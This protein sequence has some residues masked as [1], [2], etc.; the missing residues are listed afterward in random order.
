MHHRHIFPGL[1]TTCCFQRG[2]RAERRTAKTEE[3][4]PGS[5]KWIFVHVF[6]TLILKVLIRVRTRTSLMSATSSFIFSC[7]MATKCQPGDGCSS[8]MSGMNSRSQE[9]SISLFSSQLR[10][11]CWKSSVWRILPDSIPA[12]VCP[13]WTELE[14]TSVLSSV[15][16]LDV[17]CTLLSVSLGIPIC[18]LFTLVLLDTWAHRTRIT[19]N[20][21]LARIR[22]RKRERRL[23]G[24]NPPV[25]SLS[26]KQTEMKSDTKVLCKHQTSWLRKTFWGRAARGLRVGTEPSI[27]AHDWLQVWHYRWCNISS[28]RDLWT[29]Q[30]RTSSTYVRC[31]TSVWW[32]WPTTNMDIT[33]TVT[34]STVAVTWISSRCTNVSGGKRYCVPMQGLIQ[35][36]CW[37]SPSDPIAFFCVV[38]KNWLSTSGKKKLNKVFVTLFWTYHCP[39]ACGW[40]CAI[41][42]WSVQWKRLDWQGT[43][44]RNTSSQEIPNGIRCRTEAISTQKC[45]RVV[46]FIHFTTFSC[47]ASCSRGWKSWNLFLLCS[48][49]TTCLSPQV[50]VRREP[51]TGREHR[52]KAENVQRDESFLPELH[53][54]CEAKPNWIS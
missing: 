26:Q 18:S 53:W 15:S 41:V 28:G 4:T 42:E 29:I 43:N 7:R 12:A 1:G 33:F 19:V 22:P 35:G 5:M 54:S 36:L 40:F 47:N 10:C 14:E 31:A 20:C 45:A 34:P 8:Q 27:L 24:L 52:G 25:F 16:L 11:S 32:R 6:T 3:T 50:S 17:Q 49:I 37:S 44:V 2:S 48:L 9:N 46:S 23:M 51:P 38:M 13:I 30:L 39:Q 21:Q